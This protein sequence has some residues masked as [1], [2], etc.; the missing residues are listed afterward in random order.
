MQ[1]RFLNG[2]TALFLSMI[3]LRIPAA[4]NPEHSTNEKHCQEQPVIIKTLIHFQNTT[5]AMC[6]KY[7]NTCI[8][9]LR[10]DLPGSKN[11]PLPTML[12]APFISILLY[13][14]LFIHIH[15]VKERTTLP[16]LPWHPL[17]IIYRVIPLDYRRRR[18]L[19]KG[20]EWGGMDQ[21]RIGKRQKGRMR[22]K[23]GRKNVNKEVCPE[24]LGIDEQKSKVSKEN[25]WKDMHRAQSGGKKQRGF[26]RVL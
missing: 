16:L 10:Y 8:P 25:T 12:P 2:G 6:H 11:L 1:G 23:A 21:K 19:W 26:V 22:E 5:F 4:R 7:P 9:P 18:F 14:F 13:S 24:K 17:V 20:A 3:L 15:F